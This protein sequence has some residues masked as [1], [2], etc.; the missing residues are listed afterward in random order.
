MHYLEINWKKIWP[1]LGIK[2]SNWKVEGN[3]LP[4]IYDESII[5]LK[6]TNWDS[7]FLCYKTSKNLMWKEIDYADLVNEETW[8]SFSFQVSN[9][10]VLKII[11]WDINLIAQVWK[12]LKYYK[13]FWKIVTTLET[14]WDK[15]KITPLGYYDVFVSYDNNY[16]YPVILNEEKE[17]NSD[18]KKFYDYYGYKSYTDNSWEKHV[19]MLIE[20]D[21]SSEYN[22]KWYFVDNF[23]II[24]EK[25]DFGDDSEYVEDWELDWD[26]DIIMTLTSWRKAYLLRWERNIKTWTKPVKPK[27]K[28]FV[29]T[30]AFED[31]DIDLIVWKNIDGYFLIDRTKSRLSESEQTS[32]VF[33]KD[34]LHYEKDDKLFVLENKAAEVVLFDEKGSELLVTDLENDN[35]ILEVHL[36]IDKKV[37]EVIF[38]KEGEKFSRKYLI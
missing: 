13:N 2:Y 19:V 12:G 8:E 22:P 38:E 31:T 35:K 36:S 29:F 10:F 32:L 6:W 4:I 21:W 27:A 18:I 37:A 24:S 5:D 1:Y 11:S 33:H 7:Y 3:I 28:E 17:F 9:I 30:R 26:L 23:K 14:D 20:N 16:Y 34:F 15:A 25:L